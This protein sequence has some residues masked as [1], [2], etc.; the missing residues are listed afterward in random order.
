MKLF[1][2]T[3]IG[4]S[5]IITNTGYIIG[6]LAIHIWTILIVYE[7]HGLF[8]SVVSFFLPVFS[9][10]Y[11]MVLSTFK[12]GFINTYN[13]FIIGFFLLTWISP[14]IMGLA[15]NKLEKI[16]A[17]DENFIELKE[18]DTMLV[19]KKSDTIILK[20]SSI[21]LGFLF[22]GLII[23]IL[24]SYL[25]K[26]TMESQIN[27]DGEEN[28][29]SQG[30]DDIPQIE[31]NISH[32]E[33]SLP[34]KVLEDENSQVIIP[35]TNDLTELYSAYLLRISK[36]NAIY[37][38]AAI[39]WETGSTIEILENSQ[40]EYEEWD[41]LLNDIY[42]TLK[43]NLDD[44]QFIELRELQREWINKRD[45]VAKEAS[46]PFEGGTLESPIYISIQANETKLRCYWL[47][48]NYMQ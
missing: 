44:V 11:I 13:L 19:R 7:L 1:L 35:S 10:L 3:I 2:Q 43:E 4:V 30:N 34:I 14:I 24:V 41:K 31:D 18:D 33:K 23:F 36:I 26:P 48:Q 21:K 16:I 22:L 27:P 40:K 9:Q 39:V 47:V 45:E 5:S 38:D 42:N 8:G 20:K 29:I 46:L 6:G 28:Y 25:N 32:I 17:N 12:V 37:E 15:F